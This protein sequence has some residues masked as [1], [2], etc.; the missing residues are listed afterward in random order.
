[1]GLRKKRKKSAL[2]DVSHFLKVKRFTCSPTI[3]L[4]LARVTLWKEHTKYLCCASVLGRKENLT[5][6]GNH[7]RV[8]PEI[9]E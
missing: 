7:S 9:E 4:I 2:L 6:L 5:Q 8:G 1:M 3:L